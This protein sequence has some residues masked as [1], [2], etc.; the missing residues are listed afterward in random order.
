MY[1]LARYAAYHKRTILVALT[2]LLVAVAADLSGPFVAKRMINHDVLGVEQTWYAVANRQS[3]VVEYDGTLYKRSDTFRTRPAGNRPAASIVQVGQTF[4]F[5][6][7]SL[8]YR[9]QPTVTDGKITVHNGKQSLTVQGVPLSRQ[10]LFAFYRPSI[11][12]MWQL[13]ALYFVLILISAGFTYGQQLLLQISANRILQRMRRDVFCHIHRLPIQYFDSMPAGKVVSRITNDTETLRD[14]YVTVLANVVS[15]LITMFGIY[16]ALFILDVRLALFCCLLLPILA[17]WVI[18][19]RKY[20]VSINHRI[21]SLLSDLNAMINETIQGIPVIRAFNRQQRTI[22]EF[23]HINEEFYQNQTKLLAINS[24]TSHNLATAVRNMFFVVVLAIFGW[25]FFHLP[26]AIS[27]GALYAF[28]DYLGRLFSPVVQIVNQ[29]SNIELARVSA[30]RVFTLL[31]E[32][33]MDVAD[34]AMP[35]Y[36]GDVSFDEVYFS[37]DGQ[38]D[39]LR[40]ISFQARQGE[41]VA[42]VGHTG[43]GKSSIMN[44]LFRFYDVR[45]GQITI[46]GMD[47]ATLPRQHLRRHMGIVLQDPFLF[48]GTIAS[49]VSLGDPAVDPVQVEQALKSVGADKLLGHLPNG[50][51]SLVLE[52]GSTLSA[53]Q[54]QLISFARALAFNPAILVLDEATASIDTETEAAIQEAL[55]VVKRGRTTFIIAHRLS[56]IRSADLILVMDKGTIVERGTHEELMEMGGR[57]HHMYQLQKGSASA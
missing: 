17:V 2:L 39:V 11:P 53:G 48:T 45:R 46:D 47:I 15:S 31:D 18:V 54:R 3:G 5:V 33:G 28:V 10:Q 25:R 13:A 29:L 38:K 34:G 8:P 27:F 41:T 30:E 32:P 4:Y 24:G 22:E 51:D 14:F 57:Y 6:G 21:R 7:R 12:E 26:G 55:E 42:L 50:W 49:N 36:H 56:T 16:V 44:L 9:N 23:D 19:Y 35:R 20:A 40:G 52:K 37:Y 1:R 43:S